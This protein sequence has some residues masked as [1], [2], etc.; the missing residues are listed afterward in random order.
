MSSR[1]PGPTRRI[2]DAR[3]AI[4]KVI[5]NTVPLP[6][7]SHKTHNKTLKGYTPLRNPGKIRPPMKRAFSP[8]CR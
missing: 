3:R 6:E 4:D 1:V 5:G 7:N 8:R 2:Y